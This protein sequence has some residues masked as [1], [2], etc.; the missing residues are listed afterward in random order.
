MIAGGGSAPPVRLSILGF[1]SCFSCRVWF[2]FEPIAKL[3]KVALKFDG[4]GNNAGAPRSMKSDSPIKGMTKEQAIEESIR[5]TKVQ[6]RV[7][8]GLAQRFQRPVDHLWEVVNG[9]L[10]WRTKFDAMTF[11]EQQSI[12]ADGKSRFCVGA[13]FEKMF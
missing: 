12:I 11:E 4:R 2:T 10:K 9:I 1:T 3:S 13:K 5:I 8:K 6:V 7:D